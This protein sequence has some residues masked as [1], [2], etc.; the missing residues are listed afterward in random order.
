MSE[1][2][3]MQ[4]ALFSPIYATVALLAFGALVQAVSTAAMNRRIARVMK[5]PAAKPDLRSV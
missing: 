4:Q 2:Q 5:E 1:A 3:L